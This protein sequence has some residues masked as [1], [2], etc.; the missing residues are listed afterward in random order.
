MIQLGGV[1]NNSDQ[2]ERNVFQEA[3][4]DLLIIGETMQVVNTGEIDHLDS[5]PAQDDACGEQIDGHA[6][7]VTDP[8]G[9]A[10]KTVEKSRFARV[11]HTDDGKP[12]HCQEE[13]ETRAA[14]QRRMI[15]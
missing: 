15:R 13:M 12:F 9:R 8:R 1:E 6:W 5:L 10:G 7:P 2:V 14:S 3:A 4:Y 11:G